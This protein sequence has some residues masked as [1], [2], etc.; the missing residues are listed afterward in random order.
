M[1][2]HLAQKMDEINQTIKKIIELEYRSAL[3]KGLLDSASI[4]NKIWDVL[5]DKNAIT[6]PAPE[7]ACGCYENTDE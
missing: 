4:A 5:I 6:V 3:N 1:N 7:S 2:K